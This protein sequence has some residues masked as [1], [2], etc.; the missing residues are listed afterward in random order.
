MI[1]FFN[2]FSRIILIFIYTL[3]LASFQ[4]QAH[5]STAAFNENIVIK[6]TGTIKSFR[7]INP[8]SSFKIY[9]DADLEDWP[10]G[11]W[12]IEM[13]AAN[14]LIRQGWKRNS[15]RPGDKVTVFV[16]PLHNVITLKD[17]SQGALYIG[18]ILANGST[19]GRVDGK[20]IHYSEQTGKAAKISE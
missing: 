8:H 3:S 18:I 9:A 12:T 20:G 13:T 14:A 4:V 19:L 1:N 17:G 7:W 10:D 11:M 6:L 5:H 2:Q 16:H 15:I